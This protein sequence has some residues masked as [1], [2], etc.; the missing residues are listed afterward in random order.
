MFRTFKIMETGRERWRTHIIVVQK[1]NH[2]DMIVQN[3]IS[4]M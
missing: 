1:T 2:Q 4:K 3:K